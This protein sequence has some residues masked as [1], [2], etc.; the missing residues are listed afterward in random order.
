RP[1]SMPLPL[2]HARSQASRFDL[3]AVPA[4]AVQAAIRARMAGGDP[5]DA[6]TRHMLERSFEIDLSEVRIHTDSAA[7]HLTR[8]VQTDAFAA[9]PHLFFRRGAYQPHT[10]TGLGLVAHEVTHTLQQARG[11]AALSPADQEAEA[12]RAADHVAAGRR[13]RPYRRPAR[14]AGEH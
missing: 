7:D 14:L 3:P 2:D 9:G 12:D 10:P 6:Q 4:P 5:L 13:V 8:T 11:E 1:H